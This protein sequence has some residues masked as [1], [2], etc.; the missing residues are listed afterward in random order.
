VSMSSCF[1]LYDINLFPAIPNRW[2]LGESLSTIPAA[3]PQHLQVKMRDFVLYLSMGNSKH[4]CRY[5]TLRTLRALRE[6]IVFTFFASHWT[7]CA[8]RIIN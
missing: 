7:I 4:V 6:K 3:S 8:V 1:T 5:F 2:G